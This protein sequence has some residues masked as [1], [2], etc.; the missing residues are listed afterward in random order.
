MEEKV[1]EQFFE[2][3]SWRKLL[4]TAAVLIVT[5][6][7]LIVLEKAV[8]LLAERFPRYRQVPN[9]FYPLARVF[10]WGVITIFV[11]VVILDPPDTVLFTLLGSTGLAIGLAAQDGLRNMLAGLMIMFNPPYRV[12][13]M[14]EL[15]GHYGEVIKLDWSVTWLRTFDDSVVMVPNGEILKNTVS[16]SSAGS[17]DELVKVEID[18]PVQADH[19]QAIALA[20]EAAACSPYVYLKKPI[21]VITS[22]R[23]EFGRPLVRLTLKTYVM[24]VRLERRFASDITE[25]VLDAYKEAGILPSLAA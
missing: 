13:D 15:A 3:L 17:L 22:T 14:I 4:N 1:I 9:R 16:N 24:D 19:H 8:S 23:Y 11:I 21:I 20:K 5:W 7:V 25:R 18:I 2:L 6:L 10:I 12:G